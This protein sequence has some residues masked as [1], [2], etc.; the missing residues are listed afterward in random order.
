MEVSFHLVVPSAA[1]S[2]C[3]PAKIVWN[4]DRMSVLIVLLL[5]WLVPKQVVVDISFGGVCCRYVVRDIVGNVL[6]FCQLQSHGSSFFWV[7]CCLLSF[8]VMAWH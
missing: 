5:L 2:S 3:N 7:L 1:I 4:T 6:L 8:F